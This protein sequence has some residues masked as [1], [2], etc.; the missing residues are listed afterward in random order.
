LRYS[1]GKYLYKVDL[2]KTEDNVTVVSEVTDAA[3][4]MAVNPLQ[5]NLLY[6][7]FASKVYTL[8]LTKDVND[9]SAKTEIVSSGLNTVTGICFDAKG[10]AYLAE[11]NGRHGI[12]MITS[13]GALIKVI[14]NG[15]GNVEGGQA[16]AKMTSPSSID[17]G[18]NGCLYLSQHNA[19]GRIYKYTP[20]QPAD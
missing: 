11:R 20:Y 7:V 2:S 9:A 8:D 5:P 4:D 15:S 17:F 18:G 19:G 14:G 6:Y 16:T 10:N 1:L 13:D 3:L 12:W